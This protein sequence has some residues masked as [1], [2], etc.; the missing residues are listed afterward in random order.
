MSRTKADD[1]ATE[2]ET[3]ELDTETIEKVTEPVIEST[4]K[5]VTTKVSKEPEVATTLKAKKSNKMGVEIY[6]QKNPQPYEIAY[7]LRSK[8]R[9]AVMTYE[10]WN[11][12]L[13]ALMS[14]KV[15]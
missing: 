1:I 15:S 7:L 10:E 11:E 9:S 13:E 4:I 6:L 8:Y 14:E 2:V 5:P 3:K 12:T